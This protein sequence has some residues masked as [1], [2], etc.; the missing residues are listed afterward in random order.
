M[1]GT[2]VVAS[3]AQQATVAATT[4]E[5]SQGPDQDWPLQAVAEGPNHRATVAPMRVRFDNLYPTLT[6]VTRQRVREWARG[7]GGG[8]RRVA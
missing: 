4:I 1:R 7:P 2:S 8:Q 5:I 6:A 3:G